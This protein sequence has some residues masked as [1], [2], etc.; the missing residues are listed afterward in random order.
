MNDKPEMKLVP[1]E[2]TDEMLDDAYAEDEIYSHVASPDDIY[3]AM[4]KDAPTVQEVDLELLHQNPK[5]TD[6]N[7]DYQ[8]GFLDAIIEFKKY[9]KIYAVK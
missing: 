4:T 9:G 1:V 5:L 7:Y 8:C 3:K 6:A 2:P